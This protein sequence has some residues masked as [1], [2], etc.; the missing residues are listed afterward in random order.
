ME[1]WIT[2][3]RDGLE[4]GFR[5]RLRNLGTRPEPYTW[6]LHV[7]HAI[8]PTSRFFLP[9]TRLAVVDPG[10]S[11]FGAEC[12]EVSWPVHDG[13]DLQ[14][15]L[16]PER[17]LTEWLYPVDLQEGSCAVV[18][19]N[20]IGLA[21]AF[22]PGIF[23]TVWTWGVYGGWRGHY[24]LLTEPSTSPPGGLAASVA[25][26]TAAL[27]E[28]GAVLETEVVATILEDQAAT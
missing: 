18:H 22:D 12:R 25:A 9:A 26:G 14:R 21:L 1:K 27:I 13:E 8:E 16:G 4:I 28:P 3:R 15:V 5:H 6:S 10:S 7:A 24:V 20:G 2:V 23:R 17:G 11:R 19:Q